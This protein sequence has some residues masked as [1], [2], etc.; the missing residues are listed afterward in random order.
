M[1]SKSRTDEHKAYFVY[2]SG[3]IAI[4]TGR[5]NEVPRMKAAFH[6]NEVSWAMVVARTR[7]VA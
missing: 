2:G 4:P 3:L 7:K 1:E 5:L 6:A